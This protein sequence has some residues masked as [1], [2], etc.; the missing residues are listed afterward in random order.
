MAMLNDQRV[1]VFFFFGGEWM[2]W[3]R[4]NVPIKTWPGWGSETHLDGSPK[5]GCLNSAN[6][7][8]VITWICDMHFETSWNGIKEKKRTQDWNNVLQRVCFPDAAWP[9]AD[10]PFFIQA[11]SRTH[12]WQWL[13]AIL[14]DVLRQYLLTTN[15]LWP[16]CY[17]LEIQSGETS[18]IRR[19]FI[20]WTPQKF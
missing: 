11:Y 1:Y 10:S 4:V 14:Q 20:S 16:I 6:P 13:T 9:T 3:R 7:K 12:E 19:W 5:W 15:F 8:H 18:A 17:L 2:I